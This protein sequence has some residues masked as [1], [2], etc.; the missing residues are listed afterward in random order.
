MYSIGKHSLYSLTD[1][2]ISNANGQ[3][4]QEMWFEIHVERQ[5][6]QNNRAGPTRGPNVHTRL[7]KFQDYHSDLK[8]GWR[9]DLI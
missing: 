4:F 8:K 5:D 7:F 3:L 6:R 2:L 1:D 9:T